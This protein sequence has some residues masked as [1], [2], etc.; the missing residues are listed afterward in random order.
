MMNISLGSGWRWNDPEEH[1]IV[2]DP[3]SIARFHFEARKCGTK[4]P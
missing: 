4:M 3:R 1:Y 2:Q